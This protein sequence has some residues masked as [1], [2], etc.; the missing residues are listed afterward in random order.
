MVEIE[1]SGGFAKSTGWWRRQV[2]LGRRAWCRQRAGRNSHTRSA[3]L[4]W[5]YVP[6]RP[7]D[8]A[9]AAASLHKLLAILHVPQR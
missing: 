9:I 3:K 6:H 1:G 2:P 7:V 8:V 4:P 5:T